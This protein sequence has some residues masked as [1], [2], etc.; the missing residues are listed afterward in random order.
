MPGTTIPG[1]SGERGEAFTKS[2]RFSQEL[3][4]LALQRHTEMIRN[5]MEINMK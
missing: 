2:K 5:D 4:A 3:A 1:L